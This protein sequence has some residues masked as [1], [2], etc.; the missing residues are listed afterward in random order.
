MNLTEAKLLARS[1]TKG[2][3]V[4]LD[5]W[6]SV[7]AVLLARVD[8]LEAKLPPQ[9]LADVIKESDDKASW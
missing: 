8:E 5:G 4:S 7:I 1:W 3:D 2:Q 6:R 9:T